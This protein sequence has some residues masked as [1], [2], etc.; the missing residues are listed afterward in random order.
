MHWYLFKPSA[1]LR[2]F[3]SSRARA[4]SCVTSDY[5]M[6]MPL[7]LCD[8]PPQCAMLDRDL[9]HALHVYI[10]VPCPL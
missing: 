2:A 8:C 10:C 4:M 5:L 3:L 6:H 1:A 9:G 7:G